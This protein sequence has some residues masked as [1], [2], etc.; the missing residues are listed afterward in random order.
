MYSAVKK[1][2]P[3]IEV[4]TTL[5]ACEMAQVKTPF[6]NKT[7]NISLILRNKTHQKVEVLIAA[8][9]RKGAGSHDY[10]RLMLDR[11]KLTPQKID[12]IA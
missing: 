12:F 6:L 4:E 7:R 9:L 3:I 2:S 5:S 11:L 8:L 10:S 1:S